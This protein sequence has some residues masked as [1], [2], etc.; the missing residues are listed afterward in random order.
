MLAG[1]Y[2]REARGPAQPPVKAISY[3]PL[4]GALLRQ[5]LVDAR[6]LEPVVNTE[7]SAN[8]APTRG[9]RRPAEAQGQP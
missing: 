4:F 9:S 5:E 1:G 6:R 2:Q 7:D 8:C 3:S